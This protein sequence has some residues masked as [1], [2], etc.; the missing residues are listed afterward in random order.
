MAV[1]DKLH[2]ECK[3]LLEEVPWAVYMC[4]FCGTDTGNENIANAIKP[5]DK[6]GC[7]HI[8]Y[9][10]GTCVSKLEALQNCTSGCPACAYLEKVG[11][12]CRLCQ[13]HCLSVTSTVLHLEQVEADEHEESEHVPD[14]QVCDYD[15]NGNP[16]EMHSDRRELYREL[17][18]DSDT[19][20]QETTLGTGVSGCCG[21]RLSGENK[22]FAECTVP[23]LQTLIVCRMRESDKEVEGSDED[24]EES[25]EEVEGSDEEVEESDEKKRIAQLACYKEEIATLKRKYKTLK[26]ISQHDLESRIRA[27]TGLDE[28]RKRRKRAES[29]LHQTKIDFD[30]RLTNAMRFQR[31][32]KSEL[33]QVLKNY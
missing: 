27:E 25:D 22:P 23:E 28:E 16:V 4:S 3:Q 1:N 29:A 31:A 15:D 9:A 24:V 10:C 32:M 13:M 17:F 5:W 12:M 14:A 8:H 21:E 18:G 2:Q 26:D 11:K 33:L 30:K 20:S 7:A 19:D 6:G